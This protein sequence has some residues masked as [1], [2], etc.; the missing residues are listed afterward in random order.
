M[1]EEQQEDLLRRVAEAGLGADDVDLIRGIFESYAYVSKLIE[2]KQISMNR[3][4]KLLFGA[5]TEKTANVVG[6]NAADSPVPT[7]TTE[8][9][10]ATD[11]AG[12]AVPENSGECA[13]DKASSTS[14]KGHGRNG[15]ADYPGAT[16]IPVRHESLQGGDTCPGCQSGTVYAVTEPGVLVRFIGQAPLQATIYEIEKLRCHRCGQIFTAQAPADVGP[17]KYDATAVAMMA[18]LKYGTGMPFNRSE[19]MQDNLGIPLPASTQWEA[20]SGGASQLRPIWDELIRQ[21]AQGTVLHNDDTGVKILERMGLRAREQALEETARDGE[22]PQRTGLFTT[23]IVAECGEHRV[24]LF[25]SGN[26][27]AGEN[28][29]RVLQERAAALGPPIQMCDALSRNQ[30]TEFRTLLANC[31]A[32]ARRQFVDV[33]ECFPEECRHVLESLEAVYRNDAVARESKL[34]ADERLALHQTHSGPVMNELGE[35]CRRQLDEKRVEANSGLGAAI[36]YLLRHW[37]KL[38]LFLRVAGAPLDNNLV[39]RALKKAILHRKN[40][41]FYK[42]QNGATVGD[43]YMSLIHTCELGRVN[44]HDYL[45]ALLRNAEQ[46]A[47]APQQWLPWNYQAVARKAA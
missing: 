10:A 34:T 36:A 42:T 33:H 44:P 6:R 47:A 19:R 37:V 15:A 26:Q 17:E 1:N 21:A 38:T 14:K 18:L 31:L 41:L 40:S 9:T 7:G 24:A 30:P 29:G 46:L 35:W 43:L 39:E 25:F 28:L 20:V 23:G 27:H 11:A 12:A 2:C 4:Q 8:N 32:H 3:L 13:P 5:P 45:T 16:R 22:G